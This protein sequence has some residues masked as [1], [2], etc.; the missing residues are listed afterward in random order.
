MR[1]VIIT[2]SGRSGTSLAAGTLAAGSN[3]FVGGIPHTAN[4]AN[5]KGFFETHEVGGINE[6]LLAAR[7]PRTPRLSAGQRWLGI[8]ER[9]AHEVSIDPG[10]DEAIAGLTQQRPWCFKDPRFVW[11]LDAWRPH[12]ADPVV[13]C[14]F[15]EP[16]VT[17]ESIV[18]EC[19]KAPYLASVEMDVERALE[20]WNAMYAE[21]LRRADQEPDW[22]FIHYDQLMTPEGQ[23]RLA[24]W[25]G[26][27]LARDF[28]D[29][30]LKRTRS[31]HPVSAETAAL[32]EKLCAR[33]EIDASSAPVVRAAEATPTEPLAERPEL[34]VILC[35]YNRIETL[36]HSL[37]TYQEQTAA[38]RF[39]LIVVNDGST[40][41]T[42][43]LLDE[44]E[45]EVP[46]RVVHR[47]NGKLAAARNT[48]IEA[49]RGRILLFVND[50]TLAFPD[51][52]EQHL[53]MHAEQGDRSVAVLGTFEQPAAALDDAMT[54]CLEESDLV[55]RY[56]DMSHGEAYDYNRFWTCNVSV[57]AERVHAAG[58]FD[59]SFQH[60]GAEDIDLGVRLAELGVEVVYNDR[61][62]AH[63]EHIIDFDAFRRRSRLVA[64]AFVR[65]FTKHP[66][67]LEHPDFSWMRGE[68]VVSLERTIA[69][70]RA[71]LAG[72]E[73]STR[74]LASIDLGAIERAEGESEAS[75]RR[76]TAAIGERLREGLQELNVHW[77][78]EGFVLGLNEF[79]L[80]S[81]EELYMSREVEPVAVSESELEGVVQAIERA[82]E[83]ALAGEIDVA[84]VDV[85]R[86]A[87]AIDASGGKAQHGL[88]ELYLAAL[89]DL[90]VLRYK[91]SDV[92]GAK[93][94]LDAAL[95]IDPDNELAKANRVD[96]ETGCLMQ[97]VHQARRAQQA[98]PTLVSD[99]SPWVQEALDLG[100][101]LVGFHGKDVVE[102]G[103]AVPQQAALGTGATSWRASL[104]NA[105]P[106]QDGAYQID[107][108]NARELPYADESCDV[109]F[110]SCA[111]QHIDQL[112]VALAEVR[113]VL[114]P[115][116]SFVTS[117][118]PIWSCAVG[119]NLWE[120][121]DQGA[122]ICFDQAVLPAWG[123]L[124]LTPEELRWYLGVVFSPSVARRAVSQIFENPYLNRVFD[125]DFRR[126]FK[127]S[128]MSTSGMRPMPAWNGGEP[129]QAMRSVLEAMYPGGS[130]FAVPGYVGTLTKVAAG[131]RTSQGDQRTGTLSTLQS[132]RTRM[133]GVG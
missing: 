36:K 75:C 111:F 71:R 124:L 20:L 49:A 122:P 67:C 53:A 12:L 78:R 1:D 115:G 17:A 58:G 99:V 30:G 9:E 121:D 54:R 22:K 74:E 81:F 112:D 25:T 48:G 55:F 21:A 91:R 128:G 90:A 114:R 102:V 56:G 45:F 106:T 103:G 41:G 40:D 126:F 77:W 38:G 118:A 14:V 69:E 110:S 52:I 100:E 10:L 104:L 37:A 129:T 13:V 84:T 47:P 131:V 50:D 120:R 76:L 80:A 73:E 29:P 7:L 61:A 43:E 46:T 95:E 119:H 60:Y 18:K 101:R 97:E 33:A 82:R 107:K 94:I 133:G 8:P 44:M 108:A 4:D 96:V 57:E 11:T 59:E 72:F 93:R 31:T 64:K 19:A 117:F 65:L 6:A 3:L 116:G 113:R 98:G 127:S 92:R 86:M 123:H 87:A 34:S 63:H 70:E 27:E 83:V 89:N 28:P 2:G 26:A 130:D 23:Q 105:T 51:M 5:P 125:A 42:R 39:E 24:A 32:Y 88:R 132:A 66:K 62:R 16:A 68:S 35:T 109:V 15:R 85:I 79:G